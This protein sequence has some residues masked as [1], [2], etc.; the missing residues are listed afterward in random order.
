[1]LICGG[2]ELASNTGAAEMMLHTF[3]VTN[4]DAYTM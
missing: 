4:H 3:S 2:P 1:M